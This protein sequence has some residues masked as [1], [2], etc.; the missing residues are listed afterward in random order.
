MRN[1]GDMFPKGQT[2]ADLGL[3]ILTS[4]S[5]LV[6]IP[7]W[8]F[9]RPRSEWPHHGWE[10]CNDSPRTGLPGCGHHLRGFRMRDTVTGW[11]CSKA[12][13]HWSCQGCRHHGRFQTFT[14]SFT[15]NTALSEDY[16][17]RSDLGVGLEKIAKQESPLLTSA[18]SLVS[19]M[20]P[21][22]WEPISLSIKYCCISCIWWFI[23]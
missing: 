19:P 15:S 23:K 1:E 11:A 6:C 20:V 16:I 17:M 22:L 3:F 9:N 10:G 4:S 5:S 21:S 13:S 14:I 8:D 18:K 7:G 2:W 12:H